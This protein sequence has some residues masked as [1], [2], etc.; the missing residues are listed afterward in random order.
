MTKFIECL[1]WKG[2]KWEDAG[3]DLFWLGDVMVNKDEMRRRWKDKEKRECRR[4]DKHYN[5]R[6]RG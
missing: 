1:K 4:R 5:E 2:R 3:G 6:V